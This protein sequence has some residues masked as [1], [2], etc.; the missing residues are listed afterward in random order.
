MKAKEAAVRYE[1]RPLSDVLGAEVSGLD[2]RQPLEKET[3]DELLDAFYRYQVLVFRG[4]SLAIPEQ[5]RACKQFGEVEPHPLTENTCEH[6]EITIMSNVTDDGKPVGY[7]GPPFLLW[8][9]DLCYMERPA[10][11]TFLYAHTVP[12]KGGETLFAD[13]F[14]AYDSLD[15]ALKQKL[16]GRKAVFG[17]GKKLMERCRKK[18]YDL[19]IDPRDTHPDVLHPVF[20]THPITR[21]L[22]IYVNWT[23]TDSIEGLSPRESDAILEKIYEHSTSPQYVHS[24]SYRQG[25]LIVWDNAS[26]LHTPTVTEPQYARTMHRMVLRGEKPY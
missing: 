22:A 6:P 11:M 1:V 2:L 3:V 21:K 14:K 26:T 7:S 13:M 12:A 19:Q 15:P 16:H 18:G 17:S 23:H 25:D 10:K 20:R 4:Q 9:S 24:H 5:I 8:H